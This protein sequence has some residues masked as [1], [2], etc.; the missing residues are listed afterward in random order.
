M[1]SVDPVCCTPRMLVELARPNSPDWRRLLQA[2]SGE[3]AARY[4]TEPWAGTTGRTD[5]FWLA[6]NP[7]RLAVGC[8][9][10]RMPGD[11]AVDTSG[12]A[13]AQRSCSKRAASKR[14]RLPSTTGQIVSLL[15]IAPFA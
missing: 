8:I 10:L 6:R 5:H 15:L 9:A 11:G 7:E 2:H 1:R 13:P 4:P 12:S 3:M 14:K